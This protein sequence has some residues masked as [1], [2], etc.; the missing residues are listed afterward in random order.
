MSMPTKEEL[1]AAIEKALAAKADEDEI[2]AHRA[3]V[4]NRH[5]EILDQ[6]YRNQ[7]ESD[8]HHNRASIKR[9]RQNPGAIRRRAR[10]YYDC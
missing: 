5:G 9:Q 2:A 8:N 10:K 4:V 7:G 6:R 1:R 3:K